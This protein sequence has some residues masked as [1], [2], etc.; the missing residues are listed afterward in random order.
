[1]QT[2]KVEAPSTIANLV[3]GFDIFGMAIAS[4]SDTLTLTRVSQPGITLEHFDDFGLPTDPDK[5]IVGVVLKA[6]HQQFPMTGG[7]HAQIRKAVRPGS[8]LGSSA[9]SAVAA[10]YAYYELF[11]RS[12]QSLPDA[13]SLQS[14][15]W[16]SGMPLPTQDDILEWAM[17]GEEFA[18]GTR[19]ADNL[20][21]CFIGGITLVRTVPS[22]QITPLRIP[23][24]FV[25]VLH[26]NCTIRTE[27]A[28]SILPQEISLKTGIRQLEFVAGFV[29]GLEQNN[30]QL[31][32]DSMYDEFAQPFRSKLI[33]GFSEVMQAGKSSGAIGG[34]IAG[35][36]PA[37]FMFTEGESEA[38]QVAQAMENT[39]RKGGTDCT[40]WVTK[41]SRQGVRCVDSC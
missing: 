36:G 37:L 2:V 13:Q 26:P 22:L 25:V 24:L 31:I 17:C 35:S 34:G 29:A 10:A 23:D 5:N 6:A 16:H 41:I 14:L 28:R 19:H 32:A 18:S 30:L 20:A 8:G 3:C 9:S 40:S 7:L 33:P 39:F 1:M 27:A 12:V 11:L 21:P 15:N 4:P 38:K